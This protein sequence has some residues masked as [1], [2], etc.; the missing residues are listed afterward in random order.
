ML[1]LPYPT[2][3]LLLLQEC[4]QTPATLTPTPTLTPTATPAAMSVNR[5]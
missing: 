2:L 1:I 5:H 4:K 3:I